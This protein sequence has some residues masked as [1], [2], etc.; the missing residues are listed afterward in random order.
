MPLLGGAGSPSNTMS[1][2]RGLPPYQVGIL[3]HP[4]V[5]PQRTWAENWGAVL[6]FFVGGG[7]AG[8]P[9][10]TVAG[11]EPYHHSKFHLDPSNRLATIH[12][13]HRQTGLTDNGPIAWREPFYK[14]SLNNA[15]NLHHLTSHSIYSTLPHN[16]ETRRCLSACVDAEGGHFEHYL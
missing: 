4:A 16:I 7:G 15:T 11:A 5:R 14:R 2:G 9:S 6:R 8:A 3:I 13:R 10:N 1:R 12:Q